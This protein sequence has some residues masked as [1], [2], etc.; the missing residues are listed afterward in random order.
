MKANMLYFSN[1]I[2]YIFKKIVFTSIDF[3]WEFKF[4]QTIETP[5]ITHDHFAP[6]LT[7]GGTP[8]L[9]PNPSRKLVL[10]NWYI[11]RIF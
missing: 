9:G 7:R 1:G 4:N 10:L 2:A 11:G 6:N 8:Y 3:K 5:Y